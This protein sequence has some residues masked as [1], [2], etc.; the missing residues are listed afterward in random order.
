MCVCVLGIAAKKW[1]E[2]VAL[3]ERCIAGTA[4][5]NEASRAA[6]KA[7][8]HEITYKNASEEDRA[9]MLQ[10]VTDYEERFPAAGGGGGGGGGGD[11]GSGGD[12]DASEESNGGGDG[13][14]GEGGVSGDS[15]SIVSAPAV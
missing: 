1:V 10:A 8:K 9:H 2:R 7:V 14:D 5:P 4:R 15:S 12:T 11:G 6:L 13:D 3:L